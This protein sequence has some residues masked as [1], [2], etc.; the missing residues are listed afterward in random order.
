MA[1]PS[2]IRIDGREMWVGPHAASRY[3]DRVCPWLTYAEAHAQL[4]TQ[5]RSVGTWQG[6]RP[7][8]LRERPDGTIPAHTT[9]FVM[10][11]P[12]IVFPVIR[13]TLT[14]CLTQGGL[15][16]AARDRRKGKRLR[17]QRMRAIGQRGTMGQAR[18]D[19]GGEA[20]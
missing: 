6:E 14:T 5:L 15:S 3:R 18:H 1:C 16:E 17:K 4:A 11:G 2:R 7:T 9:G 19:F 8:F 12:G 13:Q 20:A 10:L